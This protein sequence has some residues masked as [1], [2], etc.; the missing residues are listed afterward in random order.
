MLTA[1]LC[2][3]FLAVFSFLLELAV[4]FGYTKYRLTYVFGGVIFFLN[5]L[6]LINL[7]R[8]TN[9][10]GIPAETTVSKHWINAVILSIES[11]YTRDDLIALYI[12]GFVILLITAVWRVFNFKLMSQN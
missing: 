10:Y 9:Q 6:L 5:V 11:F 12:I 7:R 3:I 4:V 2:L 8:S 1:T